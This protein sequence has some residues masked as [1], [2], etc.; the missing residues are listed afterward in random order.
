MKHL[1]ETGRSALSSKYFSSRLT[2]EMLTRYS[3]SQYARPQVGPMIVATEFLIRLERD[4]IPNM[5]R[6]EYIVF[7]RYIYT[8]FTRD[9]MRGLRP[10]LLRSLYAD[11]PAPDLVI[12]LDGTSELALS[13]RQRNLSFFE[14]GYDIY[15]GPE[16]APRNFVLFENGCISQAELSASFLWFQN[17]V[18]N[19]YRSLREYP[20]FLIIDSSA[21]VSELSNTICSR[22]DSL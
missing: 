4:I 9:V 19:Q 14:S 6:Y 11:A 3:R 5:N 1:A 12:Y 15:G 18:L 10:E 2:R 22:I 13:R 8:A 16:N 17:G 7:D 20:E 21:P